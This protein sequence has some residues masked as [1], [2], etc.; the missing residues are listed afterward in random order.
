MIAVRRIDL[1]ERDATVDRFRKRHIEYVDGV[2]VR[3]IGLDVLVIPGARPQDAIAIL[4][5]PGLA[6][7]VATIEP[8]LAGLGLDNRVNAV[9]ARGR[10]PSRLACTC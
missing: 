3:R 8:A 2:L 10:A 9:R 6:V 1:L 7:V 4:E 5:F